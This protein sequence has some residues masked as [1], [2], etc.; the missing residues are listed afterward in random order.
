[1]AA[2]ISPLHRYVRRIFMSPLKVTEDEACSYFGR[3][4]DRLIFSF[5]LP[6]VLSQWLYFLRQRIFTA[7]KRCW[8]LSAFAILALFECYKVPKTRETESFCYHI[9][10]PGFVSSGFMKCSE[11]RVSS[12]W[13]AQKECFAHPWDT[14]HIS[15]GRRAYGQ[16]LGWW[17]PFK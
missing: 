15:F 8:S 11:Y 13:T 10:S 17:G 16:C 14:F 12:I 4:F 3:H 6:D 1:M 9:P 7:S 2:L 5:V